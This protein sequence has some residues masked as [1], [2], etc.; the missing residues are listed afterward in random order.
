MFY[1]LI[2]IYTYTETLFRPKTAAIH[3]LLAR[4]TYETLMCNKQRVS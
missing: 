4:L 3:F 2:K 1:T